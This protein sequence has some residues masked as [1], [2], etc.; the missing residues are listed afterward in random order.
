[1]TDERRL[2]LKGL[3]CPLPVLKARRALARLPAGTRLAVEATD[4]MSAID[5]PHMCAED[6]HDLIETRRDG[7]LLVFVIV[8]GP[9]PKRPENPET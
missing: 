1:M 3:N 4:P 7:R 6:G 9:Q 5:I 8:A 2:D